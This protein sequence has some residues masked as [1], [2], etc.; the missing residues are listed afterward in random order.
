MRKHYYL[1]WIKS[2]YKLLLEPGRS[3]VADAGILVTRIEYLKHQS[4]K[5]FAV[6]D[7]G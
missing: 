2:P 4:S 5:N 3:I 7:K 1:N 6:V